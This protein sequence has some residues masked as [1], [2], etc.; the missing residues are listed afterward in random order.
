MAARQ[1][2][3]HK[4]WIWR[5]SLT[6]LHLAYALF[7]P[8]RVQ[9][10]HKIPARGPVILVANHVSFLDIPLVAIAVLHRHVAFV[11]RRSLTQGA[12][13]RIVLSGAGTILVEPGKPDR[14]ALKAMQT[15]LELGGLVGVFPEG[16]R[17]EDG[18]LKPPK[19]GVSVVA[20]KTQ[21]AIIPCAVLG[22]YQAWPRRSRWP[23]PGRLEVRF[24]DPVDG[25]RA[26][27]LEQAWDQ[28][29]KLIGDAVPNT[30][31]T[32]TNTPELRTSSLT[33]RD[34]P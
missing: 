17:S 14:A 29:S 34:N 16:T 3:V 27:A 23:K 4:T 12:L 10:R 26:D 24:G 15:H 2:V 5:V 25:S 30:P 31:E 1:P 18:A 32:N 28:I 9:G 19:K 7:W 8:L 20:R 13:L 21:A 22:T 11:A 6:L 33:H